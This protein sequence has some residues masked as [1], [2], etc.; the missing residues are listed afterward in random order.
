[1][2]PFDRIMAGVCRAKVF[3]PRGGA[4]AAHAGCGSAPADAAPSVE[5]GVDAANVSVENRPARRRRRSRVCPL[6]PT[7]SSG[8]RA[9]GKGG[10]TFSWPFA[11]SASESRL[12]EHH[13]DPTC[14]P[15]P[16]WFRRRRHAR[17]FCSVATPK[18]AT[19]FPSSSWSA[20]SRRTDGTQ[21]LH[22]RVTADVHN[23]EGAASS[24]SQEGVLST[25]DL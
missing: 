7:E 25:A 20:P 8:W 14:S 23:S 9:S 11:A 12:R 21:W 1:V 18:C 22:V 24:A 13:G 19:S 17:N 16:R 3:R 6:A 10:F 2:T 15:E 5:G 4:R